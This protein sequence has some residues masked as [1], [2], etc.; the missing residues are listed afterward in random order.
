MWFTLFFP[1]SLFAFGP[2]SVANG[3][4]VSVLKEYAEVFNDQLNRLIAGEF[5]YAAFIGPNL[6]SLFGLNRGEYFRLILNHPHELTIPIAMISL[7]TK[8]ESADDIKKMVLH[9]LNQPSNDNAFSNMIAALMQKVAELIEITALDYKLT[10]QDRVETIEYL[11]QCYSKILQILLKSRSG[12]CEFERQ[13][14]KEYMEL[15]QKAFILQTEE[16]DLLFQTDPRLIISKYLFS[17]E[18]KINAEKKYRIAIA[19]EC[20]VRNLVR[21]ILEM[22]PSEFLPFLES[23]GPRSLCLFLFFGYS[24]SSYRRCHFEG[25]LPRMAIKILKEPSFNK[26]FNEYLNFK[27]ING[28]TAK[29]ILNRLSQ[30]AD[31]IK[32]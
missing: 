12:P 19:E 2:F 7:I 8:G 31:E 18:E 1:L 20:I 9:H 22:G 6:N 32:Q 24:V 13:I 17:L 3:F 11:S 28:N 16:R 5:G 10:I 29:K 15:W 26:K 14:F 25:S 23:N 21:K 27:D 4:K 30:L